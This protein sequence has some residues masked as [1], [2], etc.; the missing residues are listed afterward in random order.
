MEYYHTQK[1]NAHM[2]RR[3]HNNADAHMMYTNANNQTN[4]KHAVEGLFSR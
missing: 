2:N 4:E 1:N 3:A